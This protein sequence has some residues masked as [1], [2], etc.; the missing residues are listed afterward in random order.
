MP[1]DPPLSE[2]EIEIL[3]MVA[4]GAT[5]SEVAEALHISEKAVKT[6]LQR[7]FDEIQRRNTPDP[8]AVA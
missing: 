4:H 8:P 1:D 3:R 5:N 2:R 6:H 7:I